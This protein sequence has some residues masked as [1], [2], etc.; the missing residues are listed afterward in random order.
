MKY[1][2]KEVIQ[3]VNEANQDIAYNWQ[4]EP[5]LNPEKWEEYFTFEED[6][7]IDCSAQA[8]QKNHDAL[9]A[10]AL[11][12]ENPRRVC[13]LVMTNLVLEELAGEKNVE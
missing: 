6:G 5:Y 12:H 7:S 2:L 8:Q 9:I 13:Q 10:L 4:G 3:K 1:N 11:T